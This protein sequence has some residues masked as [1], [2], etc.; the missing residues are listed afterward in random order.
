M[1]RVYIR[2]NNYSFKKQVL[3]EKQCSSPDMQRL[4]DHH[5]VGLFPDMQHLSPDTR[6]SLITDLYGAR[7]GS[8]QLLM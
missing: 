6:L 7:S 3:S 8:P 5:A 2:G 1:S 4:C